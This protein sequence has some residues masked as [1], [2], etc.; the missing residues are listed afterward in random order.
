MVIRL[1][2][3]IVTLGVARARQVRVA[4][5]ASSRGTFDLRGV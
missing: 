1:T 5:A 2:T 4:P 3:A